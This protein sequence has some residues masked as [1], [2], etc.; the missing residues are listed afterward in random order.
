MTTFGDRLFQFGG[1]PVGGDLLGLHGAG[2]VR[3]LD[4]DNGSDSNSGKTP[5]KAWAT[6]QKGAD[7]LGYFKTNG[8]MNGFND[9]LIRLP[10]VEEVDTEVR[11]DGGGSTTAKGSHITVVSSL[12]G[13]RTWGDVLHAHTR[14]SSAGATSAG[15][16][17]N[18]VVVVRRQINF[19]GMSFAGRGTG[20]RGD[21]NGACLTYRVNAGD[22]GIHQG[23]N[24]HTVRGCNFRDDGGN[25]T[26]GIYEYGAGA[27]EIVEN[28]FGY[29]AASRGPVGI[30]V[31]GSGSNNP[32]DINITNNFFNTCPIGIHFLDATL[33]NGILVRE[34]MF[35]GNTLAMRFAEGFLQTGRGLIVD[36]RFDTATGTASWVNDGANTDSV[37]D[38]GTDT[39]FEFAG[40][41]YADDSG[42][43]V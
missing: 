7:S 33:T 13:L 2:L 42:P 9:I 36:N 12:A 4:P 31:R 11:F 23:G 35:M 43:G 17:V 27:S 10:G 32:F 25:D 39:S 19:Y 34:N 5:E 37:A 24:F 16:G 6:L 28:T 40:N 22:T 3:W 21:G 29:N 38:V 15:A 14:M 30:V 26:T 1:T 8:D 41:G 18:T 20:S